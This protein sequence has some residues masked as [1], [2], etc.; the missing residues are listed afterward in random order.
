MWPRVIEGMLGC[1]MLVTPFVFRGTPSL[2]DYATI[3]LIS[4][5]LLILTSLL[6]FWHRTSFARFGTL[7][8]A[9]WLAGHGYLSA[10]R[11]GPPGAQNEL[12]I[13]VLLLLFAVLPNETN[14]PPE[15]WRA[16]RRQSP[17]E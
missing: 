5:G 12:T 10:P 11:P 15:A 8:V 3:A 4:G 13:G 2:D 6:S 17:Q 1:W 14:R 16:P 7:A 9:F